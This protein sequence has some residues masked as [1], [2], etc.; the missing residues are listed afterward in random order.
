MKSEDTR[1]WWLQEMGLDFLGKSGDE[2]YCICPYCGR[3]KKHFSFNI[4]K[5]VFHCFG[6]D[7]SGSFFDLQEQLAVDLA[8]GLNEKELRK[9]SKDRRLPTDAF[10]GFDVGF[11]GRFYTFPVRDSEGRIH[12]VLRYKIG[13]KPKCAPACR[14]GLLGVQHLA[15]K[16]RQNEPAYLV[17]GLGDVVAFEW[18]RKKAHKPGVV[19]GM[20][21]AGLLPD[22][23]IDLFRGREVF[24]AQDNDEAGARGEARIAAKLTNVASELR[25]YRWGED[26]FLGKDMRDVTTDG[27]M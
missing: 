19:L 21:G 26:D 8:E 25:F 2:V 14:M 6:C 15:D 7:A 23:C 4:S 20:L 11:T 18:L 27:L 9:L 3:G 12:N 16:S 1:L 22:N 17:E 13:D 24:V 5:M 10:E